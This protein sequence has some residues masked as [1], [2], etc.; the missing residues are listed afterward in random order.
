MTLLARA[1]ASLK[2]FSLVNGR[3]FMHRGL[4]AFAVTLALFSISPAQIKVACIGNSITQGSGSAVYPARLQT[5]LGSGYSVQNDGVSATTLLKSGD[6][7]YWT[8]GKLASVFTFQPAIVTIK[9]GTNDTKPQNWDAHNTEF[10]RDYLAL[11]DTLNTLPTKPRIFLVLPVPI[12]TNTYGIRDSALQK[13]MVIIRQIALERGLPLVDCNTPLKNFQ[14]YF[15]DG[16][17]PNAAG[18]DTIARVIQRSVAGAPAVRFQFC[19]YRSTEGTLPFRLFIPE[20]YSRSQ[21][22]PL[23]LTLHGVGESGTTNIDHVAKNRVAEVWA[24]D[25]T[26]KKQKCF[27]AS[28]QCPTSDKWVNVPQWTNN[29]YSTQSIAQTAAMTL[30]LKM[31]DSLV[32]AYPIDTN[33]LYVTGLSMGGY[34]TWDILARHPGKFAAAAPL[35]GGCDTSKVSAVRQAPIWT[36]HGAQDPTVPPAATRAMMTKIKVA[37]DSVVQFTAQYANYFSNSTIS[38]AALT[39]GI[40][41]GQKKIFCE[42]TDAGHDIWT[43]T[44]NEPLLARWLF[45]QV[46]GP[47][48]GVRPE[49]QSLSKISG[50]A[51][52]IPVFA[53]HNLSSLAGSLRPGARYEILVFDVRGVM[54]HRIIVDG[55]SAA[56]RGS[57]LSSLKSAQTIRWVSVRKQK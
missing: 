48:T 25:S 55:A 57:V 10:K 30:A 42:Y 43:K 18:A 49:L 28:P 11:I 47:A 35:C 54:I 29:F 9:L 12:W 37:G 6:F 15:S 53:G 32:K 8:N 14:Q 51:H 50:A 23:I 38:R 52:P 56:K 24:E 7:S 40:D 31:V 16:V 20:N 19:S 41:S 5:F 1:S 44:Y 13:I 45:K 22:Y 27:V 17:H 36:F 4:T 46:K 33:R 21:K 2:L 34:G 3:S 26:Q 39:S